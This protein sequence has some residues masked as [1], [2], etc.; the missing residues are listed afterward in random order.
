MEKPRRNHVTPIGAWKTLDGYRRVSGHCRTFTLFLYSTLTD[1]TGQLEMNRC[2]SLHAIAAFVAT[3]LSVVSPASGLSKCK[4]IASLDMHT[5][6]SRGIYV[7]ILIGGRTV[8]LL[9]DTGGILSMLTQ[10]T[11]DALSIPSQAVVGKHIVMIG[12]TFIERSVTAHDIN[13][14]GVKMA[15]MEFLVMPDGHLPPGI[16]GT[17]SPDVLREYVDEFDFASGKF[18]LYSQNSCAGVPVAWT[19]G[20]HVEIPFK[21]DGAGHITLTARLDGKDVTTSLDTG[22]SLSILRL[23][24]AESIFGFDDRSPLLKLAAQTPAARIYQYPF[25]SLEFGE[26]AAGIG[27]VSVTNPNLSLISRADT[28]MIYGPELI[29][30]MSVLRNL[31][32]YIDYKQQKIYATRALPNS[33]PMESSGGDVDGSTGG[34]RAH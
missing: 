23:E 13:L 11:I 26:A 7:P 31:N 12:G 15:N 8:N 19:F 4:A 33:A 3:F 22:S 34:F 29:L 27:I 32:M 16:G 21:L 5:M 24:S 28:G 2:A 30:G 1:G 20:P 17:L 6:G 18:N 25:H 14:G 9:I 10:S